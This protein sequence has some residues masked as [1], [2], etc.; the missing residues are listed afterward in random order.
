ML[1][2]RAAGFS[3]IGGIVHH[4][5]GFHSIF[6][7]LTDKGFVGFFCANQIA[8]GNWLAIRSKIFLCI[9]LFVAQMEYS[10]DKVSVPSQTYTLP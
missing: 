7:K 10:R 9:V 5:G 4:L 6:F 8:R 3:E 1:L 2:I